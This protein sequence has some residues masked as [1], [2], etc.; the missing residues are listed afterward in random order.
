M[1]ARSGTQSDKF[2]GKCRTERPGG[3]LSGQTY[4]TLSIII[5]SKTKSKGLEIRFGNARQRLKAEQQRRRLKVFTTIELD[6]EFGQY[7]SRPHVPGHLEP[8]RSCR[9]RLDKGLGVL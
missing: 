5:N 3:L 7:F 9:R 2:A 6:D 1:V 8:G 4:E